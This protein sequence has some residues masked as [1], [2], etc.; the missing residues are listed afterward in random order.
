MQL[1]DSTYFFVIQQTKTDE[2]AIPL[3]ISIIGSTLEN[4]S[5]R[6]RPELYLTKKKSAKTAEF[7]IFDYSFVFLC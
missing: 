2:F 3:T 4:Y 7:G 6:A 1:V 5:N